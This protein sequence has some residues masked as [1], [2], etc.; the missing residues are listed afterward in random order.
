MILQLADRFVRT[1]RGLVEDVLVRIDTCYFLVD[2][3]IL[4]MEPA[5][6]LTQTPIILG[7]PFLATAKANI[8]CAKGTMDISVGD[9]KISLNIFQASQ[10]MRDN[11]D[12]FTV[13][14][15]D[16]LVEENCNMNQIEDFDELRGCE[17]NINEDAG[18]LQPTNIESKSE[19]SLPSIESPPPLELKPLPDSLKYVF[20]GPN[21]TLPII[22]VVDLTLEQEVQL[23]EVLRDH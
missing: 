6:Q 17:K 2:F 12:C 9:Q 10:H 11:E 4:D 19:P 16:S 8:D 7:R 22:I 5:Q 18:E 21:K 1:P 3:L 14:V 13:D 23:I 20:L 15:I